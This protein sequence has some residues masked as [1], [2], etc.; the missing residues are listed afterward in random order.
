MVTVKIFSP[1]TLLSTPG[2][3]G[4]LSGEN[5]LACSN[6]TCPGLCPFFLLTEK[7]SNKS[8]IKRKKY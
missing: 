3:D 5:A 7:T 6:G 1:K 2:F 4:C 8:S